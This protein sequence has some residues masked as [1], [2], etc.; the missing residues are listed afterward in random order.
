LTK[1]VLENII[2]VVKNMK[3]AVVLVILMLLPA[4][5]IAQNAPELKGQPYLTKGSTSLFNPS[6]LRMQQSYTL[7]YYSGGGASGSIGYYL[8]SLEY[9]ISNPLKVRL[10]LGF[11]HNPGALFSNGSNISK[12]SA[13]VPGFSVDWRPPS[14]FHFM[15]DFRQVPAFGYG[16]NN[17]YY[18]RDLWEDYH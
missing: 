13:F 7:G 10:D 16:G 2:Q 5:V 15:L 17:G 14:S 8:N 3:K 6:R 1:A 18:N 11:V 12:S 9:T 4:A